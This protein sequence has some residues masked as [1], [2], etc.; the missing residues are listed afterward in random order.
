M[1]H[2]LKGLV[3]VGQ[4]DRRATGQPSGLGFATEPANG[5]NGL[6]EEV[7]PDGLRDVAERRASALAPEVLE[8]AF[9][10]AAAPASFLGSLEV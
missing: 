2:A 1:R 7:V 5:F 10:I 4:C 6:A 3:L 9:D 8:S